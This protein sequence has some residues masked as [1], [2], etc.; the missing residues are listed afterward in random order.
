M[1]HTQMCAQDI[2]ARVYAKMEEDRLFHLCST[3]ND[4]RIVNEHECYNCWREWSYNDI[5]GDA[6]TRVTHRRLH[7]WGAVYQDY[8]NAE[9]KDEWIMNFY[10]DGLEDSDV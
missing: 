2:W 3:C 10:D 7:F 1:Y 5:E 6:R 4:T 9:D 8:L